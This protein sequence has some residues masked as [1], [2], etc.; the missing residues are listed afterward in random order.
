MHPI[1]R[2]QLH[3]DVLSEKLDLLLDVLGADREVMNAVR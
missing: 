3:A 1:E 2:D